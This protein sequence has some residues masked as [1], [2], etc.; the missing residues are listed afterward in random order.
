MNLSH[1]ILCVCQCVVCR[2]SR[3]HHQHSGSSSLVCVVG[4]DGEVG[5]FKVL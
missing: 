3:E 1:L 4:Q 2:R 5:V